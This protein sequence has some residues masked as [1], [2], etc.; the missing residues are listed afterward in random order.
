MNKYTSDKKLEKEKKKQEKLKKKNKSSLL[1]TLSQVSK[2][3]IA[4]VSF[5]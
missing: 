2:E 4:T 1:N 5:D 3:N